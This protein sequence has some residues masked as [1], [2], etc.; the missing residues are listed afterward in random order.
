MTLNFFYRLEDGSLGPLVASAWIAGNGNEGYPWPEGLIEFF[1]VD[2]TRLPGGLSQWKDRDARF[3]VRLRDELKKH[4]VV[5]NRESLKPWTRLA[6]ENIH[7][8]GLTIFPFVSATLI[9]DDGVEFDPANAIP[10]YT[11]NPA[12]A[13]EPLRLP[14]F[15]PEILAEETAK[16]AELQEKARQ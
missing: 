11:S 1:D 13:R 7:Q 8:Y 12:P 10:L 14:Q 3:R 2:V 5:R 6:F 16:L 4:I 15:T 9:E